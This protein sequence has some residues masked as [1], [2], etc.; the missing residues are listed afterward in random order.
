MELLE[1][2][3]TEV[4]IVVQAEID[5]VAVVTDSCLAF[6]DVLLGPLDVD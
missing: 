6:E 4:G 2:I 3:F 1:T 5:G